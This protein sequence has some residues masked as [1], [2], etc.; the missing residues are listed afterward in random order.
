MAILKP[1]V[2]D[3]HTRGAIA[4]DLGDLRSQA[5]QLARRAQ[6]DAQ[7]ILDEARAERERILE[8]AADAGREKG[9]A[10]GVAR[11]LEEGREQGKAAAQADHAAHLGA[12]TQG[13]NAALDAFQAEREA[14]LSDARHD[15]LA[16]AVALAEKVT[17]RLVELDGEIV[18]A[19]LERVLA[20][21]IE[22]TRLV[23]RVHTED[24]E[25]AEAAMPELVQ[26]F[27]SSPHTAVE[28][29]DTLTRGSCVVRTDRGTIDA[30]ID[31]QLDE[32]VTMLLPERAS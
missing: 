22:P 5:E 20:L 4:L 9:H 23:V 32:I 28:A 17:R 29:D 18:R 19:Q 16:L 21:A 8:G 2:S 26:R 10:E 7:R 1:A 6:A 15:V 25:L 31:T 12:L 13:W 24:V 27:T 14:I 11:G 3:K 30:S